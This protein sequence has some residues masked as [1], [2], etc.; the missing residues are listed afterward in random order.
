M[1]GIIVAH[2]QRR[3]KELMRDDY[4]RALSEMGWQPTV[5]QLNA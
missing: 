1:E 4:L 5:R 2:F 3:P